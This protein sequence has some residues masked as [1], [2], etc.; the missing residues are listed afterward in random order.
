[1]KD[2]L[3]ETQL[4]V[5]ERLIPKYVPDEYAAEAGRELVA[6]HRILLSAN[7]TLSF[8]NMKLKAALKEAYQLINTRNRSGAEAYE[9]LT[10][11]LRSHA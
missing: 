5:L 11:G 9:K 2:V 8:E 10:K 4:L 3:N 6:S 7:A 1:M